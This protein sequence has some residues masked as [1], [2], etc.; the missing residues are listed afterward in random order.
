MIMKEAEE[1]IAKLIN[2][3]H[4]TGEE[5]VILLNACKEPRLYIPEGKPLSN[6]WESALTSNNHSIAIT[7]SCNI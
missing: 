3:R 1:I 2:E 4:I 5:A 7:S 6:R